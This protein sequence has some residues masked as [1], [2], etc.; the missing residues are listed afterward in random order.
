MSEIDQLVASLNS[1]LEVKNEARDRALA[2]SRR[3]IRHAANAI[4]ALHRGETEA[5]QA[6]IEQGRAIVRATRE[7]LRRY[8]D[9][10]WT[11]Y[12]QD[13]Q[14]EYAEAALVAAMISGRQLPDPS[15]LE[16]EIAP[17]LNGLAEAASEMRRYLLDL[18]LRGGAEEMERAAGILRIMDD[19]Y[20]SLLTVDFP[21]AITG[22][23]RRSTDQLRAVL[24]RSRGDLA[25]TTRQVALEQALERARR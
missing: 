20:T 6:Q 10:Y 23:L 24:E 14:K 15:G 22:G 4:R 11:G 2:D 19:V 7:E 9:I 1:Q 12:V 25:L 16:L 3:T 5:A 17:Y 18:I 21:D 8:P 13:A